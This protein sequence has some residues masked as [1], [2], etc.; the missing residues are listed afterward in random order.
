[1]WFDELE[2]HHHWII[3]ISHDD[4]INH[5]SSLTFRKHWLLRLLKVFAFLP[6]SSTDEVMLGGNKS[7]A[8]IKY[9]IAKLSN[10]LSAVSLGFEAK[11]KKEMNFIRR[12]LVCLFITTYKTR[13]PNHISSWTVPVFLI[14][15]SYIILPFGA[16]AIKIFKA[17]KYKQKRF[18]STICAWAAVRNDSWQ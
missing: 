3:F 15:Q 14:S 6:G 18:I 1:M 8:S 17:T 12:I 4:F 9:N 7:W 11:K 5:H 10:F 16:T 2:V 13:K